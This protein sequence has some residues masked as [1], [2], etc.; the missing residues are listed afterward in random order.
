MLLESVGVMKGR[1]TPNGYCTQGDLA[2]HQTMLVRAEPGAY[3][4]LMSDNS[5]IR[6]GWP[7]SYADVIPNLTHRQRGDVIRLGNPRWGTPEAIEQRHAACHAVA[8]VSGAI[9]IGG[10]EHTVAA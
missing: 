6:K 4:Q 10:R 9:T 3:E 5:F 7:K 1:S 8:D 2:G